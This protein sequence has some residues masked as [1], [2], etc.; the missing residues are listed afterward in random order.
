[1][2]E[3]KASASS[4]RTLAR[5]LGAIVRQIQALVRRREGHVMR[6]CETL[7]LGD[8][9]FLAVVVVEE[10]RFLVGGAGNS[11]ALL[12]QLPGSAAPGAEIDQLVSRF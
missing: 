2:I 3:Y 11:I 9:R 4:K 5:V 6:L 8:R 10:Q 7:S 1:M 12:A